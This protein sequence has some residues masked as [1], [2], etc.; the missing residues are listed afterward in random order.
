[1]GDLGKEFFLLF[2]LIEQII[3]HFDQG[4]VQNGQFPVNPIRYGAFKISAADFA[5]ESDQA[6][7]GIGNGPGQK[8]G[9]GYRHQDANQG[10]AQ[11]Y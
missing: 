4:F 9:R 5:A 6:V 1:M 3:A 10:N 11:K 8:P 7:N 2:L